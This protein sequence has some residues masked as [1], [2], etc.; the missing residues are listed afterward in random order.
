MGSAIVQKALN[1]NQTSNLLLLLLFSFFYHILD[2]LSIHCLYMVCVILYLLDSLLL[3]LLIL[4]YFLY[5]LDVHILHLHMSILVMVFPNIYLLKFPNLLRFPRIFQIFL[6]LLYLDTS[7]LCCYLLL[8]RHEVCSLQQT[9]FPLDNIIVVCH[10]SS[11][12][13]MSACVFLC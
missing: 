8:I 3:F 7:S 1:L 12:A 4:L 11:N 10:I 6:F 13:D 5:T 2:I 9:N